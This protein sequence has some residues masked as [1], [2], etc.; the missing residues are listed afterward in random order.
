M[1]QIGQNQRQREYFITLP[2]VG[3]NQT[4]DNVVW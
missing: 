4:S 1:E 3:T 2:A